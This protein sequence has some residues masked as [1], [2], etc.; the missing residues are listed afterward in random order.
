M[1][2]APFYLFIFSLI[3]APL[4]FGL[5]EYWSLG[6]I[7]AVVPLAVLVLSVSLFRNREHPRHTPGL[8][9][10]FLLLGWMAFQLIPLPPFIVKTIAPSIFEAYRPLLDLSDKPFWIPLTVQ[11]KA[12]L[13]ELIRFSTCGLF[14]FL[15]VQLLSLKNRLQKTVTIVAWLGVFIALEAIIQQLTSPDAIY[16]I[17]PA[18]S[19]TRPIGPWVYCN[20]FAGFMEMVFPL[21]LALFL[22]YRPKLSYDEPLRD[23]IIALF[24]MPGTNQYLLFGTGAILMAVSILLSAS[25]GGIITLSLAMLFFVLMSSRGTGQW[26]NRWAALLTISVLLIISW[27]GWNPIMTKFAGIWGE[28]G[29]NTSGRLPVLLDTMNMVRD[30]PLTGSGFG[31]YE[32]A[33]PA[34]RTLPGEGNIFDHAHNDYMELLATGGLTGFLLAAWFVTAVIVHVIRTI[35]RRRDQYNL[36]VTTAALTGIA[37]LLLHCF[38]D[39]QMYNGANALYFFFICGLAVSAANTRMQYRTRPTLLPGA[40]KMQGPLTAVLALSVLVCGVWYN[41]GD[42]LARRSFAPL[43]G[44]YL[45]INIPEAKLTSMYQ[46]AATSAGYDQLEGEY[47][48]TMAAVSTFLGLPARAKDEYLQAATLNPFQGRYI[49]QLALSL[50]P[51]QSKAAENL[52]ALGCRYEPLI[53]DRYLVYSSHLMAIGKRDKALA[54]IGRPLKLHPNWIA[55]LNGFI[56]FNQLTREETETMLP[57]HPQ[58]WYEMG[59]L[60]EKEGRKQEAAHYYRRALEQLTDYEAR[61]E[62]FSRLYNLYLRQKEDSKALA[63]LRSGISHLPDNASFHKML[64]DNYRKQGISYRAIE[65]YRQALLLNPKDR[66]LQRKLKEMQE[67]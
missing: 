22:F 40:Q 35:R 41:S 49:Q 29:L 67:K 23:R 12:T 63:V 26:R 24:T 15:T 9:P 48:F 4:A 66:S 2:R 56:F 62:Y 57:P 51:G 33:F 45:N 36:L 13:Q 55:Q 20:H 16:W 11:P 31:T 8:M 19:A 3:F 44:I 5:V 47:P 39:F 1:M 54:A 30:F 50:K 10:L 18:P 17:R 34:Y 52:L 27:L 46:R 61:P 21:V 6:L 37:A 42:Y 25:R 64:G 59:R 58:A 65:E 53:L 7:E 60:M 38:V 43:R 14:F 28:Q 32:V